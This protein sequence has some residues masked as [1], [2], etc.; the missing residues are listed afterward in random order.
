MLPRPATDKKHY[1]PTFVP[2]ATILII[3]LAYR[4]TSQLN[5]GELSS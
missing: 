2:C 3:V 4:P 5:S 1:L